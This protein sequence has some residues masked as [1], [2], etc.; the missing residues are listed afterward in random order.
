MEAAQTGSPRCSRAQSECMYR[1]TDS[2]N[3]ISAGGISGRARYLEESG[4][5]AG[6]PRSLRREGTKQGRSRCDRTGGG[7]NRHCRNRVDAPL[8]GR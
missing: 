8:K 5:S 6:T 1:S 7:S 4:C 2:M 3:S